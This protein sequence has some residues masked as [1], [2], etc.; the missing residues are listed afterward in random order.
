MVFGVIINILVLFMLIVGGL[1]IF[2]VLIGMYIIVVIYFL[3]FGVIV[4]IMVGGLKV[5]IL[6]DWVYIFILLFIIIIFVLIVYVFYDLLGFFS[7]VYDLFVEVVICYLVDGNKEGS[8]LIM[9]F[10]EG[11]IFFVINIV[12]NFGIVFFDNGYYNKVIVVLFVYVFF[13]YIIGGICWFVIFW[14]IV[15]IM[16]F[17]GFVFENNFC[18]FIYFDCMFDF[19]VS[20]GLVFFYVVVVF[21]GKGGVMVILFIVF[22]VV[23]SV[24]FSQL[25]V[26][27]IICIYD[28]YC[29]YFKFEVSGKRLIYMSYCVVV[30]YGLFIFIFLVGLWYVGIFMGYFYVMMGVII[31]LVV[32]FVILVLFWFGQNKW[33]VVGVFVFGF[34]ILFIVWFVIFKK[35]CGEFI[36]QCIGFNIF[37]LVGNVVVLFFFVVFIV[38]FI[39]IFGVDK[40]DWKF[41]LEICRGDDYDF[42]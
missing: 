33:V 13:G 19:D 15:I 32:L 28:L 34:V 42:V 2:N 23:I 39:V 40:Y 21:F 20:V 6:I 10:R 41:M 29:V 26:V 4:Y 18:F 38:I 8:Y 30:G 9:Q 22:M 35:Q 3:L 16:G 5:I 7:V 12:G 36:V 37:M 25:I 14:F 31:L 27:S 1:V 24:F 11:V 17:V